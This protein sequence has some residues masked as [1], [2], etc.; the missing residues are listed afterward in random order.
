[1]PIPTRAVPNS[2]AAGGNGTT[3]PVIWVSFSIVPKVNTTDVGSRVPAV[4]D[5][6]EKTN[7]PVPFMY[8]EKCPSVTEAFPV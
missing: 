3:C 7:V 2:N 6:S 8:G 5:V 1:M 4:I